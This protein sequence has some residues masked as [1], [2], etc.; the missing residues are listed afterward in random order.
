M[1]LHEALRQ[2]VRDF[3]TEVLFEERLIPLLSDYK[4][5]EEFPDMKEV[6]SAFVA[7][8]FAKELCGR[9]GA[10]CGYQS[11]ADS[12]KSSFAGKR[13]FR[14]GFSDYA[15]D[16]VAFA[17]S[18]I[19]TVD[20]PTEHGFDSSVSQDGQM[21]IEEEIAELVFLSDKYYYGRGVRQNY[22]EAL[23]YCRKAAGLGHVPS[24][25]RLGS[26]YES[27]LGTG[28]DYAEARTW[29]L[30][31]AE[32]GS[33][34]A[35]SALGRMYRDGEG[36]GQDYA[37]ALRWLSKAAEQGS[38]IAEFTLGNMYQSG[39]G[40][41]A[42]DEEALKWYRRAAEKDER[43]AQC[44][45]GLMYLKGQGTAADEDE[46]VRWLQKAAGQDDDQ[47]IYTLG[48]LRLDR[49]LRGGPGS[50]E[51]CAECISL[52]RRSADL[53]NAEAALVLGNIY[54]EGKAV[55]QDHKEA[56]RLFRKAAEQG[57]AQAE[58]MIGLI[59]AEGKAVAQDFSEVHRWIKR[60]VGHG[61]SEA[62]DIL[63]WIEK[64]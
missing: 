39:Q 16:S 35:E 31:A 5:F 42:S 18:L 21:A 23:R 58:L 46:G 45:L 15:A 10:G 25:Y 59:Y 29:Y 62:K 38:A 22:T 4:A 64:R 49:M 20:E 56:L 51:D 60:S 50:E 55:P 36:T 40:V 54:Y 17:L 11:F 26:M 6:L 3:G 27:G 8:G 47:A 32:Q 2:I 57:S 48:C 34:D 53:G 30:K 13:H 52:L 33:A 1:K 24:Q 7:D 41:E 9:C 37:E 19:S 28:N 44:S 61:N 63:E 14:N 12:L 43:H